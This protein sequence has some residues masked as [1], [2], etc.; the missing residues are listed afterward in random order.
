MFFELP[1]K[2]LLVLRPD[3]LC[4]GIFLSVSILTQLMEDVKSWKCSEDHGYYITPTTLESVG[5]GKVRSLTGMVSFPLEFCC[6]VFKPFKGEILEGEVKQVSKRGCYITAGPLEDIFVHVSM[7]EG[8][9]HEGGTN[10]EFPRFTQADGSVIEIGT[11]L[12]FKIVGIKWIE[13]HRDFKALGTINEDFLGP[14]E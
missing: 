5:E 13:D 7:M 11:K 1:M 4:K 9:E 6:I 10:V 8:Y 3:Q 2:R 14:I 12:R